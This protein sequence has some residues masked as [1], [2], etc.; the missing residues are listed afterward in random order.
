MNFIDVTLDHTN[1][2]AWISGEGGLRL[3]L[4][5][6]GEWGPGSGAG[7]RLVLGIRPEAFVVTPA[8]AAAESLPAVDL[9]VA[10]VE[11][12]GDRMDL[13]LRLGPECRIIARVD[14]ADGF[15]SGQRVRVGIDPSRIHLFEPGEFGNRAGG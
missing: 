1:G 15:R 7:R 8:G 4:P 5:A 2:G 10:L 13:V 6:G 3:P 14:A 9:E 12:L 11:P